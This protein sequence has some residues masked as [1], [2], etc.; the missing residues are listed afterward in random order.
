MSKIKAYPLAWWILLSSCSPLVYA[1]NSQNVP[2]LKQKGEVIINTGFIGTES[3]NG[4]GIKA[5]AAVD[6]GF[7]L[8]VN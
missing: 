7:S 4:F 6:S 3:T 8:A 5:A 1:P 2:L